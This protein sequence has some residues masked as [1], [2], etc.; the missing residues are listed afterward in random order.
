MGKLRRT[1]ANEDVPAPKAKP[2]PEIVVHDPERTG[3]QGRRW[4]LT[5]YPFFEDDPPR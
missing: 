5:S 2:D 3:D 4:T 1:A